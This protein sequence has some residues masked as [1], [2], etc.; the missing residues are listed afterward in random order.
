MKMYI[1][2]F[3]ILVFRKIN[4]IWECI[5]NNFVRNPIKQNKL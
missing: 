5:E 1:V 3:K 2:Y 4:K